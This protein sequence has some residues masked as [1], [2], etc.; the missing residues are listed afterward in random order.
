MQNPLFVIKAGLIYQENMRNKILIIIFFYLM[1]LFLLRG[2]SYSQF[3]FTDDR[4]WITISGGLGM[5]QKSSSEYLFPRYGFIGG[6]GFAFNLF[7]IFDLQSGIYGMYSISAEKI[8]YAPPLSSLMVEGKYKPKFN[9][10]W[11]SQDVM[12]TLSESSQN[13]MYGL[14]GAGIYYVQLTRQKTESS[15]GLITGGKP[16]N[17]TRNSF[18][19]NLGFGNRIASVFYGLDVVIEIRYHFLLSFSPYPRFSS[20]VIGIMF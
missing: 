14:L 7:N 19:I 5:P 6:T 12:I 8:I 1:I 10:V 2:S 15:S 9:V 18:G 13:L 17:I 11:F 20:I 4:F 3:H 16:E